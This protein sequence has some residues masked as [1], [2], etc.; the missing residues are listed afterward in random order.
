M[1]RHRAFLLSL[2]V[3]GEIT[4]LK[5]GIT[6]DHDALHPAFNLEAAIVD[7]LGD[8]REFWRHM[9]P[10]ELRENKVLGVD[11]IGLAGPADPAI[12]TKVSTK[13]VEARH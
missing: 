9:L 5:I 11:Q 1:R 2:E 4:P 10:L 8:Y 6:I 12:I 3:T 7:C 13:H